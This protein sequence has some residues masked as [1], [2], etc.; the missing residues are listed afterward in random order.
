MTQE[1]TWR[2]QCACHTTNATHTLACC[3][4]CFI[5][6]CKENIKFGGMEAHFDDQHP[7]LAYQMKTQRRLAK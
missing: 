6:G 4:V 5:V 1:S 2:C 3:E 7:D